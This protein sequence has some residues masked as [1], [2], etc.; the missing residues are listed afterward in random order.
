MISDPKGS[1]SSLQQQKHYSSRKHQKISY[2]QE[3]SAPVQPQKCRK[4]GQPRKYIP[5]F[6][7]GMIHMPLTKGV[8]N[9]GSNPWVRL[10]FEFPK[11]LYLIQVKMSVGVC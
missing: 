11:L 3:K 9:Q 2:T 6:T 10:T 4:P 1:F 8:I 5:V 7:L